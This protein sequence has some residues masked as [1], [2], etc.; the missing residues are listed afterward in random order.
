VDGLI[1]EIRRFGSGCCFTDD[2]TAMLIRSR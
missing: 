1:E 2:A